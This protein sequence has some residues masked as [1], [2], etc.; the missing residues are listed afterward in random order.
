MSL[1]YFT[2]ILTELHQNKRKI[3]NNET[4][5]AVRLII[6]LYDFSINMKTGQKIKKIDFLN[7]IKNVF[8]YIFI[9]EKI[10]V[11]IFVYR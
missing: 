2:I 5:I 7:S 6:F 1:W 4:F 11:R 10:S 3:D 9:G 8:V